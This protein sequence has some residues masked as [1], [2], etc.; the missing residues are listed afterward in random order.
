MMTTAF[1][2]SNGLWNQCAYAFRFI[3]SYV[4]L[5]LVGRDAAVGK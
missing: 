4:R 1:D 3:N 5:A 2:V